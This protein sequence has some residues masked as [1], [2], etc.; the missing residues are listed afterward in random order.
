MTATTK[1]KWNSFFGKLNNAIR[2]EMR[3]SITL[4]DPLASSYV[5]PCGKDVE[6]DPQIT[7]Q[8]YERTAEEMEDLG[9]NDMKT[10]NYEAEI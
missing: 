2:C 10:E 3:F 4:E 5:G 9:L 8:D 6:E 7:K 1:E